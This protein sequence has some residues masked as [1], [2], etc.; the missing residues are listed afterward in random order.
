MFVDS[1]TSHSHSPIQ[2]P[3]PSLFVSFS[4]IVVLHRPSSSF[5]VLHNCT[6]L[7]FLLSHSTNSTVG[8]IS[9]I[10]YF[11]PLLAL[12]YSS[13]GPTSTL[14]RVCKGHPSR[15]PDRYT[16]HVQ[17][18]ATQLQLILI[19]TSISI[20]FSFQQNKSNATRTTLNCVAT[21]V[22]TALRFPS[23]WNSDTSV[24]FTSLLTPSPIQQQQL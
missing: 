9:H 14:K 20:H 21:S 19:Q 13:L 4:F 22:P 11:N 2:F 5:I 10:T 8:H 7:H 24:Y 17:H 15:Q 3:F 12:H 1:S 6:S 23:A 18:H 16:I